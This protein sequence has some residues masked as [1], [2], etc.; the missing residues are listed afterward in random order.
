MKV[1]YSILVVDDEESIRRLLQKELAAPYRRIQVAATA[2]DA[3]QLCRQENFEV[4]LLDIRLQ[5]GNGLELLPVFLRLL[6]DAKII[7]ITGYADVDAAVTAMRN[8]AY[9]F[10]T[11]PF[12]LD[13]LELIVDRAFE[14]TSLTRENRSL[15]LSSD[16]LQHSFIGHSSAIQHISYLLGKAAPTDVP[17]LITG[18]SGTG[19]DVVAAE[20]H[21]VSKRAAMPFVVK[22]CA[23]LQ[24]ELARSELF[25]HVRGAFTNA[26]ESHEGLVTF[27]NRG[28]LFLDE[29][30]E[31]PLEVQA[32][33]LR[34]LESKRYRRVGEKEER[35]IDVRFLFATNRNLSQEVRQGNFHEAFFHRINVFQISLPTL[36]E[37]RDDIRPLVEHFLAQLAGNNNRYVIAP[38]AMRCLLHY[39]WPGNVREL[40]NV[41]ERGIILAEN[42]VITERALPKELVESVAPQSG[43]ITEG[44]RPP[45][46]ASGTVES[47]QGFGNT[48][49]FPV[50]SYATETP[51]TV[52]SSSSQ[53]LRLDEVERNHITQVL[54]MHGGNKQQAAKTLGIAR[55]T[56][57]RKLELLE[58]TRDTEKT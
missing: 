14:Y 50:T 19:K 52:R 49:L 45:N 2:K 5:D 57:Y 51:V 9:D 36:L 56:L 4:I 54:V 22:N 15:R 18:E 55:K 39:R 24:K 47:E 16:S 33:L 31:L 42:G 7:M 40:R 53:M 26:L 12:A 37:R 32:Q 58:L 38:E 48:S 25:G 23:C 28:T 3:L 20:I 13:K 30:G 44:Q 17:V 11:K 6:P 46:A 21:R 43:A 10:V 34:I 41:I 1:D 29:V 8:R 27:A 35:S